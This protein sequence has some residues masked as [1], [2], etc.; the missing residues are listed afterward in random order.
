MQTGDVRGKVRI[1]VIVPV[2]NAANLLSHCLKSLEDQT[3]GDFEV[4][5]VDDGSTDE[6]LAVLRAWSDR[7]PLRI[8]AQEN[9]GA[10][11]ARNAALALATGDFVYMLDADDFIH[12]RL[13]EL[14]VDAIDSHHADFVLFD[15]EK[16]EPSVCDRICA[17][18]RSDRAEPQ[19]LP[20]AGSPLKWFVGK[21]MLP[22]AWRFFFRRTSL[23]GMTF[24]EGI[25]YEDN[26][27]IYSYLARAKRGVYLQKRL[28]AYVQTP[29]SVMHQA[30][31]VQRFRSMDVVMRA[32]RS[33]MDEPTW[34]WL[35]KNHY[36]V[37]FKTMWRDREEVRL[38]RE[39]TA[40][41]FRDRIVRHRDIPLRWWAK[42]FWYNV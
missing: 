23:V 30:S 24:R 26:V 25:I 7:L 16:V 22:T 21:D 27:F 11:A 28:Y 42:L 38:A 15:F 41:W 13:L 18:F 17:A 37:A 20:I 12:P 32:I 40:G 31:A 33:R 3:F 10:A 14:A 39:L 29:S 4:I 35:F 34:R 6:S 36:L 9:S 5:A 8:L 1:S 2:Y 19:V